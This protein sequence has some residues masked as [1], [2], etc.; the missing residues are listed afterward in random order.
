MAIQILRKDTYIGRDMRTHTCNIGKCE[1]GNEVMLMDQHMGAAECPEC[2]QWY[3][4]FGQKLKPPED[5]E[6]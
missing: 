6:D 1:C 3:N 5:W 2:G 4:L